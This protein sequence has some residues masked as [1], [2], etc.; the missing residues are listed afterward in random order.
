MRLMRLDI[1]PPRKQKTA[2]AQENE[3]YQNK[4]KTELIEHTLNMMGN[5][6]F[7]QKFSQRDASWRRV[8]CSAA[9]FYNKCKKC[10]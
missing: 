7:C 10:A 1:M 2:W 6:L 4:K 9:L 5:N 3:T 8:F